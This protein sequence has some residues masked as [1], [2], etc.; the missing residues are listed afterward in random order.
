MSFGKVKQIACAQVKT[1]KKDTFIL[2]RLLAA[3]MVPTRWVPPKHVRELRQLVSH[4][5]RLAGMHTQVVNRLPWRAGPGDAQCGP[6]PS[7]QS[8]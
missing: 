8:S 3:N 7:S 1:D 4:R 6:P 5:R 2:A